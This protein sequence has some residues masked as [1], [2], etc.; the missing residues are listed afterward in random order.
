MPGWLRKSSRELDMEV[1]GVSLLAA[2][3]NE[4]D[5]VDVVDEGVTAGTY[6]V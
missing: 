1:E 4:A 6:G 3:D 5:D 2:D